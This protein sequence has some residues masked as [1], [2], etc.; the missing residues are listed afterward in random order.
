[1]HNRTQ[2]HAT[3]LTLGL[4]LAIVAGGCGGGEPEVDESIEP[5][6]P[7]AEIQ[8][9][10]PKSLDLT[11]WKRSGT[12]AVLVRTGYTVPA[13][14]QDVPAFTPLAQSDLAAE[15]ALLTEY[16]YEAGVVQ[17]FEEEEGTGRIR[18]EIHQTLA[19]SEAYGLVTVS[20]AGQ[21]ASGV[22]S[23][24]SAAGVGPQAVEERTVMADRTTRANDRIM[25]CSCFV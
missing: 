5:T 21:S 18:L 17:M 19:G 12:M 16:K 9:K 10:V 23:A 13:G 24:T 14:T 11:G 20:A 6:G 22:V 7:F 2:W 1:M 4:L 8:K 25:S 15:A 3:W